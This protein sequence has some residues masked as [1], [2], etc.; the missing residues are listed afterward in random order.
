MRLSLEKCLLKSFAHCLNQVVCFFAVEYS[1]STVQVYRFDHLKKKI[2]H[3]VLTNLTLIKC[4]Q[5]T[6]VSSEGVG[7]AN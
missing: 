4:H 1:S 2:V 7:E 5:T 3:K 6:T